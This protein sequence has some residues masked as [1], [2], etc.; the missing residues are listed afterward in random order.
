MGA[1]LLRN[2][3]FTGFPW[4]EG[5]YAHVDGPLAALA[6]WIGVHGMTAVAA[7]LAYMLSLVVT[8][9]ILAGGVGFSLWKT[10]NEPD[11]SANDPYTEGAR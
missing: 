8:L 9:A 1:E 11:I 5:G 6:P 4:G 7:W 2:T 10:R 3:L